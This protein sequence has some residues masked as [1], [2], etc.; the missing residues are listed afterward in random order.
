MTDQHVRIA[1]YAVAR[2]SGRLVTIGLGSCVA[3]AMHDGKFRVAGLAHILLPDPSLSR[4]V[5]Q[6]ARFATT[7][8][9]L[10]VD[11]MRQMGA[12]GELVAKIAGGASLFGAML[13]GTGGQV[14]A[15]NVA[16]AKASLA[17]AGI[18]LVG[19]ETGGVAG[20]S[21]TLD[22]NTG[23]LHVRSVRG[24]ERVL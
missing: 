14:G 18:A 16:A 24:G 2:G 15:R 23:A 17:K 21:V 9:P 5:D 11:A 22:V 20:R 6:P 10:L 3:S 4:E 13:T 7:A 1:H 19:E 12:R 8:V